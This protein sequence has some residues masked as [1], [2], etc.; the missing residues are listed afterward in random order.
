MNRRTKR[1]IVREIETHAVRIF[2]TTMLTAVAVL[3]L[4]WSMP[5]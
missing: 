2:I 1:A 3:T 5:K 4:I